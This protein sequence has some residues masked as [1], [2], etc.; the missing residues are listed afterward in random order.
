MGKSATYKFLANNFIDY[1]PN[2]LYLNFDSLKIT[3][4]DSSHPSSNSSS[5]SQVCFYKCNISILPWLRLNKESVILADISYIALL[6]N[7]KY[8]LD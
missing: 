1:L 8:T 2:V 3:T 6:E 5:I 4:T 7:G